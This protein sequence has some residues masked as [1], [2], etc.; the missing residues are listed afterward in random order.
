MPPQARRVPQP[1]LPAPACLRDAEGGAG[2]DQPLQMGR[3]LTS[4]DVIDYDR[5]IDSQASEP[6][7][8]EDQLHRQVSTSTSPAGSLPSQG[9]RGLRFRTKSLDVSKY[10]QRS[11]CCSLVLTAHAA[12]PDANRAAT[13][14]RLGSCGKMEDADR[15]PLH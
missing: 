6:E 5:F 4:T 10:A 8:P 7:L 9:S 15:A 11:A 3:Q 14:L 12:Q 1:Q 2:S 13:M